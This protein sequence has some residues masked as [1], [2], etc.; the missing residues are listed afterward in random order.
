M[1]SMQNSLSNED[2]EV[3][4]KKFYSMLEG[5]SCILNYNRLSNADMDILVA[6]IRCLK[7]DV[8]DC[9]KVIEKRKINS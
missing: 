5:I 1:N 8:D 7:Y 6:S 9:L 4:T 3:L 2:K